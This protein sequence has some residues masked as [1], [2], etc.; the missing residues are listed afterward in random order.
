VAGRSLLD[1]AALAL[2]VLFLAI[3]AP[4]A[5]ARAVRNVGAAVE[6]AGET[7]SAARARVHD[8]EFVAAIDAIRR[9]LPVDEPY[10]LVETGD[11]AE[12]AIFWVRY[13]LAPRRAVLV[14]GRW[15]ARWLRRNVVANEI[16]WVV[17]AGGKEQPPELLPRVEYLRRLEAAR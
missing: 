9:A 5:I 16:R 14:S 17:V 3:S 15:I 11:R 8:P 1:L 6:H 4:R 13:E 12:G 2:C 7:E 10:I